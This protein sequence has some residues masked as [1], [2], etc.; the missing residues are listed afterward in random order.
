ML[1]ADLADDLLDHVL[2]GDQPADASVFVHDHGDVVVAAAEFLQQHV[3]ALALGDEDDR[4]HVL[5]D[6]EGLVARRLQPQQILGEQDAEDLVAILADHRK[7]RMARLDHQRHQGVGR[8]IT[9]DEDHL[10]ARHHDV[11]HLH[12]GDRKHALEHHQR[13]VVEQAASA[14]LAQPFDQVAEV[15]RLAGHRLRDALQPAA[16]AAMR[17]FGHGSTGY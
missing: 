10:G 13:V 11:A 2:D 6:L 14:R 1:V 3:Q 15:A 5:A 9:L 4:A 7:A 8:L 17:L 16:G 12:V